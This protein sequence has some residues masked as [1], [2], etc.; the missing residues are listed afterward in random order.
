MMLGKDQCLELVEAALEV[1]ADGTKEELRVRNLESQDD[2][3]SGRSPT[4]ARVRREPRT[5]ARSFR[6]S[7]DQ[8]EGRERR[9]T[10]G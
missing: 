8:I 2:L 4:A 5:L 10:A 6:R 1:R 7:V 3:R 9:S